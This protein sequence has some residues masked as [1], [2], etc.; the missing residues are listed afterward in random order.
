[1][2]R[3]SKLFCKGHF[4]S[5]LHLLLKK[6]RKTK[7]TLQ[8]GTLISVKVSQSIVCLDSVWDS[9]QILLAHYRT[10]DKAAKYGTHKGNITTV[11]TTAR[12]IIKT[13]ELKIKTYVPERS[14]CG[15]GAAWAPEGSRITKRKTTKEKLT[16]LYYQKD[17][18]SAECCLYM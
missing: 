11:N 9:F 7:Y 16:D 8:T 1:M 6:R 4:Q 18:D 13:T 12:S 10:L 14:A 2:P 15:Q 17:N 5:L 3:S